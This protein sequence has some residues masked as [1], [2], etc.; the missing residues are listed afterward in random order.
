MRGRKVRG[1]ALWVWDPLAS[2]IDTE[3]PVP[4]ERPHLMVGSKPD[5][6]ALSAGPNDRV[7]DACAEESL[8]RWH[9][10]MGLEEPE[11]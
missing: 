8:A 2:A 9:Q 11:D 10:R 6:V 1:S 7:F 5:R 4:P 3:L